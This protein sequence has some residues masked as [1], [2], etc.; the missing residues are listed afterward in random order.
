MKRMVKMELYRAF[1][2]KGF[3]VSMLLGAMLA[4][5]HFIFRVLPATENMFTGYH[6]DVASS[7]IGNLHGSWMGGMINAEINIYQMIVFLLVVIP[8]A[9]SYYTDK[10]SGIIQNIST[11]GQKKHYLFAKSIAVFITSGVVAL[12]PL[13]LNLMLSSMVMPLVEYDWF[14]LPAITALFKKTSVNNILLYY[15]MFG[16]VI[17]VFAG[18]VGGLALTISL[19]ANNLFVVLSLPFLLCIV[20]SRIV[21]YSG[22]AIL[23]GMAINKMFYMPQN[24]PTTYYSMGILLVALL[25]MGYV[26]FNI[27]GARCD[28]L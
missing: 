5:E 4:L 6:P 13:I 28:V 20:S 17:F 11:R 16:I 15:F 10:K 1:H 12:F 18:L 26:F 27:K 19:Y 9:G 24:S 23:K 3:V 22:N 14:Q 7:I 2:G 21:V 8:Y 25:F